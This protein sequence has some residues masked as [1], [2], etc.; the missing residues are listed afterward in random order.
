MTRIH[1]LSG[2]AILLFSGWVMW[3]AR[4]L[5]YYTGLGPGP[6]FFPFWLGMIMAALS[7]AWL[8][9]VSREGVQAVTEGFFPGRVGLMRMISIVVAMTLFGFLVDT[10]GFQLMMFAFLLF[11]L[12]ALGRQN[13]FV[14]L[15][16][17]IVG[18]FGLFSLFNNYMDAQLP[19]S[20]IAFLKNLGL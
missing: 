7:L 13:I 1:Q 20:S 4:T 8:I 6:G 19:V 9:Q 14:T 16:I 17:C 15:A 18:S 5:D 3:Q 2:L 12:T 10:I 11:L